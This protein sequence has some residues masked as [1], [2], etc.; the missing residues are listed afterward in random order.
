MEISNETRIWMVSWKSRIRRQESKGEQ[1][2]QNEGQTR[3]RLHS[4]IREAYHG[5]KTV[6]EVPTED[7]DGGLLA[8]RHHVIGLS[9]EI[10]SILGSGALPSFLTSCSMILRVQKKERM[11]K[12]AEQSLACSLSR[13]QPSYARDKL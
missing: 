2:T 1:S 8:P 5:D 7:Q 9:S 6:Q 12:M 3:G 13:G 4:E 11:G 10:P